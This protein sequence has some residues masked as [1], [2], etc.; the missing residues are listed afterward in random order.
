MSRR[1]KQSGLLKS[2][3]RQNNVIP[4]GINLVPPLFLIKERDKRQ[5]KS[6]VK[7]TLL[8]MCNIMSVCST[9]QWWA[10]ALTL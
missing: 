2:A 6:D 1:C 7:K 10:F 4:E 8:E 5:F 9:A 3:H